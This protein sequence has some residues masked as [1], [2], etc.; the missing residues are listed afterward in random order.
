[1]VL[2]LHPDLAAVAVLLIQ[3]IPFLLVRVQ[4]KQSSDQ[5]NGK[6]VSALGIKRSFN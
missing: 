5:L 4:R 6:M 2:L 3:H 1:M